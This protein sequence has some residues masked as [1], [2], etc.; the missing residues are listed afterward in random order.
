MGPLVIVEVNGPGNSSD[1]LLNTGEPHPFQEFVL[2][3]IVDAL[4]L[5]IV[6]RVSGFG[7]T[8]AYAI[9]AKFGA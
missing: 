6:F 5:G 9:I 7:H 8:D 3:R 1:N 2:H 4:R